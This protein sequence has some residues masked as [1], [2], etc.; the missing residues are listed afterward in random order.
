MPGRKDFAWEALHARS[1]EL[2]RQVF[3]GPHRVESKC[4]CSSSEVE[5]VT[6]DLAVGQIIMLLDGKQNASA[7]GADSFPYEEMG[8][9]WRIEVD[10]RE[11]GQN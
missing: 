9:R 11:L 2:V 1:G 8:A 4:P 6:I 3:D 7:H 5:F 10:T